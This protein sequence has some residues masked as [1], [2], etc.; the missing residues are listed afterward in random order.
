[1]R[2]N[3]ERRFKRALAAVGLLTRATGIHQSLEGHVGAAD[4]STTLR[5]GRI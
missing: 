3:A 1:M 5:L 4:V 2:F